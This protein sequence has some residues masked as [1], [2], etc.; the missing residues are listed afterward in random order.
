MKW[1]DLRGCV[2]TG[3][4]FGG[5]CS[6]TARTMSPL[7][8]AALS[9]KGHCTFTSLTSWKKSSLQSGFS[10]CVTQS[11]FIK[12]KGCGGTCIFPSKQS[13]R[14]FFAKYCLIKTYFQLISS[15]IKQG[16]Y[17]PLFKNPSLSSQLKY[18]SAP[19]SNEWPFI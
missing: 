18:S 3:K 8:S 12:G 7:L 16:N 4:N 10:L 2:E 5:Q 9:V 13:E 6:E 14:E 19:L 15:V 17:F 11:S 1:R